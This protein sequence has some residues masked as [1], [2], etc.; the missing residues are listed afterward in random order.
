[1]NAFLSSGSNYDIY[2]ANGSLQFLTD[3]MQELCTTA[4]FTGALCFGPL[5]FI[6]LVVEQVQT[7]EMLL[8]PCFGNGWGLWVPYVSKGLLQYIA[9]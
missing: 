4:L 2:L 3:H 8:S 7:A 1:M 6:T 9:R 5:I